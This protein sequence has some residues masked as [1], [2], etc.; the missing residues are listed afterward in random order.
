[1]LVFN[2]FCDGNPTEVR[3]LT[4]WKW[5]VSHGCVE[6]NDRPET[7]TGGCVDLE[8]W[9]IFANTLASSLQTFSL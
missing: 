4:L 3:F 5:T 6:T 2:V 9:E 1:M 8:K 7:S